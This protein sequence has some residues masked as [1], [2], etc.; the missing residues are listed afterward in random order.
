MNPELIEKNK[1][2]KEELEAARTELRTIREAI[3]GN[4]DMKKMMT[5][6]ISGYDADIIID[7]WRHNYSFTQAV[8][9][10][11]ENALQ[12]D[13][14]DMFSHKIEKMIQQANQQ[15]IGNELSSMIDDTLRDFGE[16]YK[17]N[18]LCRSIIDSILYDSGEVVFHKD[19]RNE[20]ENIVCEMERNWKINNPPAQD[21]NTESIRNAV[22][23]LHHALNGS[24][25]Q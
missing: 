14:F 15:F 22:A 5:D 13:L 2:L 21:V 7:S 23:W 10:E 19:L 3:L 20:V 9:D 6:A 24:D 11:C 4:F 18:E 25:E 8:R 12:E 17:F 16:S 1:K